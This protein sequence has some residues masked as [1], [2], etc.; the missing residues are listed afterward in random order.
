M[1]M[2]MENALI[3]LPD[4]KSIHKKLAH[5]LPETFAP[6]AKSH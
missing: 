6:L 2:S 5:L 1:L 4:S 3:A